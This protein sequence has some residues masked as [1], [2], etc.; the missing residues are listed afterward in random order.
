MTELEFEKACRGTVT[1]VRNELAWGTAGTT[2]K[3]YTLADAGQADERIANPGRGGEQLSY[4][5]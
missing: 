1:P 4:E 5:F 3:T 2:T